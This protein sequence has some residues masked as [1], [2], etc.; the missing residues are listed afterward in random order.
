MQHDETAGFIERTLSLTKPVIGLAFVQAQPEEVSRIGKAAPSTCAFWHEAETDV[1]YAAAD[2]HFNCALGAMVM[3]FPLPDDT[4][5]RLME[6]VG[7]M[8][9]T[10][11][12]R[13]EE[14]EKVPKHD[15]ASAGIVYGPL[16]R[17]PVDPDLALV[18]ATPRQAMV[19][20]E[21]SGLMNWAAGHGDVYGRPGCAAVPVALAEGRT[22]QSF[23]CVGMRIN[24]AVEDDLMLMAI[25]GGQL[26]SLVAELGRVSHVHGQLDTHYR[27][28]AAA[29]R[30]E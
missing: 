8:C 3:G 15:Q 14:V 13:E 29:V 30:A 7:M 23:G 22:A 17:F 9:G 25:P 10:S 16:N 5:G 1:F 20:A 18:W 11:Y 12:V 6:D 24:A 21:S 2:D 19:V 27:E 26:D 4:M 28:R